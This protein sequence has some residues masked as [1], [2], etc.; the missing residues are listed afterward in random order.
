MI[1]AQKNQ[2]WQSDLKDIYNADFT[3]LAKKQPFNQCLKAFSQNRTFEE[4][5]ENT[6]TWESHSPEVD[7]TKDL[8]LIYIR[9]IK[10]L[11][12]I[13][14]AETLDHWNSFYFMIWPFVFTEK[15]VLFV[16]KLFCYKYLNWSL[17]MSVIKMW[18]LL[19]K[20]TNDSRI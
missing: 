9:Y 1:L 19:N 2:Q 18:C 6:N 8:W 16:I 4:T 17:K 20:I 5:H 12:Y 15:I 3:Y 11:V 7:F 10:E 14:V 13:K